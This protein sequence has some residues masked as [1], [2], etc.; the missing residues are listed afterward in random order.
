M[1]L[2]KDGKVKNKWQMP[3][4][5]VIIFFIVLLAAV[6]THIIPTGKF[7]VFYE[8]VGENGIKIEQIAEND[9]KNIEIEGDT[10]TVD[11][12]SSMVSI[13]KGEEE[14]GSINKK[15]AKAFEYVENEDYKFRVVQVYG[16]YV[17]TGEKSKV[18][19]FEKGGGMGFLNYVYEGF[20]SGDKWGSA[21]GVM[22]FILIVGGSFGIVLKTGAVEIGIMGIISKTKGYEI[23]IIPILFFLFSLGGAVFGMGEETIPFIMILIPVMVGMGYDSIVA[24]LTVFIATQIGFGTSWMNPFSVAIAQGVAGVPIGSG[25]MFRIIMWIVFTLFGAGYTMLYAMKVKKN[26]KISIAY[27]TDEFFRKDLEK[28]KE[29]HIPFGFGHG[30]VILTL[31]LGIV[32]IIWGVNAEGYY[33]PEIATVFFAIGL[34]SGVI[35]VVFKLNDMRIN[36]IASTFKSGAQDLVGAAMVVGMAKGIILILGGVGAGNETVLNTLLNKMAMALNGIAPTIAACLMYVFQSVV[37]FFVVSGSGQAA[38]T[39]PLM[40]PLAQLIGVSKQVA[41]LAFQLGDSFTN[42]IVPTSATLMGIL[43]IAKIEWVQW[44]KFQIKL[45]AWLFGGAII[46]IL[47][48]VSIG[49]N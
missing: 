24:I 14:I 34:V 33:L 46:V 13:F 19:I 11:A 5:Y 8:L 1:N 18:K 41:V 44:L 43:A 35:G 31:V 39:M 16:D 36:D 17:T 45:Q 10:Y 49:F 27:K 28:E 20:C 25:N 38:L 47:T 15:K 37:N 4:T 42:C 2:A 7:N 32:W 22:A 21:V 29:K 48:A 6:L 9:I 40:A 12:S 3:D 26:P 23:A 30:L